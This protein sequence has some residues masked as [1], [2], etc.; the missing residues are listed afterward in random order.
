VTAA[1]EFG[2]RVEE[3]LAGINTTATGRSNLIEGSLTIEG[4][5]VSAAEFSV[6][7]ASI[8]S[9]ED[10]RNKQF[11]GKIMETTQFPTATFTLTAPIELGTVPE[12]GTQAT[13]QA[14]GDLTL[15]GVTKSV[16]FD[17]TAQQTSDK[18][19]V[20]GNVPIVFADYNI[21]NPSIAGFVT[22]EDKG[23]LEFI[24]LFE[25]A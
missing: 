3:V 2:Y 8:L 1:S 9:K 24:L 13:Y 6:D 5:S 22:T 19:G 23:L 4:T 15:H 17:L 10:R 7:V 16:T 20:Q 18:I 14:T 21:D 25:R 12:I 11:A